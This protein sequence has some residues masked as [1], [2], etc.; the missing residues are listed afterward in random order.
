MVPKLRPSDNHFDNT[1]QI[2]ETPVDLL[3]TLPDE[4]ISI[5]FCDACQPIHRNRKWR[6]A[7]YPLLLGQISRQ[8]RQYAWATSELWTTVVIR[9]DIQ[10]LAAQTELLEEWLARTMGRPIDIYFE[11]GDQLSRRWARP[12]SM[13]GR[14]PS[15]VVPMINLLA[16]CSHQWRC[17]DFHIPSFWYPIF[18]SSTNSNDQ[19][20]ESVL[21]L[22]LLM[23]ASFH[24]E[25]TVLLPH[26][27]LELDLALAPSLRMLSLSLCKTPSAIF[28]TF[29]CKRKVTSMII[30]RVHSIDLN[31]LI[32]RFPNLQEVTFHDPKFMQTPPHNA[33]ITHQKLRKL[34]INTQHEWRRHLKFL[35]IFFMFPQL[36]SLSV[37]VPLTM[38]Y[39][40][41]FQ[42]FIAPDSK[43]HLTSLSLSCKITKEF[44]LIDFLSA[45]GTLRELYIRD[46][47][48]EGTPEFGVSS[49][50]FDVLHP[51]EDSPHL[52]SLEVLSY[53]GNLV[54]QAID[55]LEPLIIRS[56]VRDGNENPDRLAVLRK[57]RI[58]ADQVS[59]SAE[60]SIAE[61]PDT[62]YVWE[63]MMMMER[64][65]LELLT[66]G[67]GRW[68]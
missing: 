66:M 15:S 63:V 39:K 23:S 57:V 55:F 17:I 8:Y 36:E 26:E 30:D 53:E 3:S 47:S 9:I 56:R 59:D 19:P 11:I 4:V 24:H 52:P 7:C 64:G 40:E 31:D 60:F 67:G 46:N 58:Q 28:A 42:R 13:P 20:T 41:L 18:I 34:E 62:Q 10:K 65:I 1:R 48:T 45:L 44:H 68:I 21:D 6:R 5:I 27:V 61:Y 51:D 32:P 29:N 12:M 14:N 25:D 35:F 49:T 33:F 43:Y 38:R 22:P 2:E 50:F 54:V 37:S 16:K